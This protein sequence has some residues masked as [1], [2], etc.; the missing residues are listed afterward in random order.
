MRITTSFS[1]YLNMN[2]CETTL[3]PKTMDFKTAVSIVKLITG[4]S[5]DKCTVRWPHHLVEALQNV[6]ETTKAIA[7]PRA[8]KP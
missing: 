3:F 5:D 6:T 2:E 7:Q 8:A 1:K 4:V